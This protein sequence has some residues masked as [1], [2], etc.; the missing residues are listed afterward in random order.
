MERRCAGVGSSLER[1]TIGG[2]SEP[3]DFVG[4]VVDEPDHGGS[5]DGEEAME[6]AVL[7]GEDV[8]VFLPFGM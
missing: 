3:L 5:S 7:F 1:L 6:E 2:S 8:G 4:R